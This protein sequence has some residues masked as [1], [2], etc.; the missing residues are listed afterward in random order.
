MPLNTCCEG[1]KI[2]IQV[3]KLLLVC[4][5]SNTNPHSLLGYYPYPLKLGK[6]ITKFKKTKVK[7]RSFENWNK[8]FLM[9]I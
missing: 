7:L 4:E 1:C 9:I 6:D 3:S 2:R 5:S 8:I